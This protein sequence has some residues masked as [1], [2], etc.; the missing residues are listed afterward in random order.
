[1][2]S[3]TANLDLEGADSDAIVKV[4]DIV[5]QLGPYVSLPKPFAYDNA[6]PQCFKL[7]EMPL[8]GVGEHVSIKHLVDVLPQYEGEIDMSKV[9]EIMSR[10]AYE[11]LPEP[12]RPKEKTEAAYSMQ[13]VV[14]K[15]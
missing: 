15:K 1:M 11:E 6:P 8:V 13:V 5:L 2:K 14:V 9:H 12:L 7:A 3:L 10:G 4:W